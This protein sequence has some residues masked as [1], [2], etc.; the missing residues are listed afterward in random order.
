VTLRGKSQDGLTGVAQNR[1]K[2]VVLIISG[3]VFI[4]LLVNQLA[5]NSYDGPVFSESRE[6]AIQSGYFM[7]D[8]VPDKDSIR[9]RNRTMQISRL[10]AEKGHEI[11]SVMIF[12]KRKKVSAG[13]FNIIT[14]VMDRCNSN[15]Y[16]FDF[17]IPNRPL[18]CLKNI[19][20]IYSVPRLPE[21]INVKVVQGDEK[22]GW[23]KKVVVDSI[24]YSRVRRHEP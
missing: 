4:W 15:E 10:W 2:K 19:G 17:D 1:M 11:E 12:F 18:N 5:I 22:L 23:Q 9:L 14:N 24:I 7:F 20:T 3:V 8:Y 21:K 13:R 6:E 16:L